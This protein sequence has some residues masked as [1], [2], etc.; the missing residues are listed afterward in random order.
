VTF[1]KREGG[2]VKVKFFAYSISFKILLVATTCASIF[3]VGVRNEGMGKSVP[4][5]AVGWFNQIL[6][7]IPGFYGWPDSIVFSLTNAFFFYGAFFCLFVVRKYIRHGRFTRN[8]WKSIFVIIALTVFSVLTV[9]HYVE[10]FVNQKRYYVDSDVIFATTESMWA[11]NAYDNII[12]IA[13][14]LQ[15]GQAAIISTLKRSVKR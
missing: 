11:L 7:T 10:K 12:A 5:I 15:I 2:V 14:L 8:G 3:E 13:M 6:S 4:A 1:E 9:L